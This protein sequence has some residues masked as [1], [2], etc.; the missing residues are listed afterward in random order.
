LP[1]PEY[2]VVN[3]ENSIFY[4]DVFVNN[5]F[6]GRGHAKNKKQAE[7]QAAK[8]FFYPPPPPPGPPPTIPY[9]N[10]KPF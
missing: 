4:I 5:T 9:L 8:R 2:R 7:Q 6:L 10:N 1:L 3:H